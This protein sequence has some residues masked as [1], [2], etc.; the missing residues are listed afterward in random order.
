MG[1][2]QLK[3]IAPQVKDV[4]EVRLEILNALRKE[5]REQARMLRRTVQGWQGATPTFE[6][7]ISFAGGDAMLLVGPGG[8]VKGA[9]KWVWLDEGT[10]PHRIVARRAP[11]LRFQT[12]YRAGS[13]PGSWSTGKAQRGQGN[14]VSVVSV[15]HPG[16]EARGWSIMLIEDRYIPFREA[17]NDAVERGLRK[18]GW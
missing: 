5:G 12:G 4:K 8:D 6:F 9:Q 11:R 16:T 3:A 10:R 15:F 2:L 14:W 18:A 7:E 13:K 17:M 1:I